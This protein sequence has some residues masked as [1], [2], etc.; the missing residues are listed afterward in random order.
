MTRFLSTLFL[1]ASSLLAQ[2]LYLEQELADDIYAGQVCTRDNWEHPCPVRLYPQPEGYRYYLEATVEV[3][4]EGLPVVTMK[5]RLSAY[6]Q[7]FDGADTNY[8]AILH[9]YFTNSLGMSLSFRRDDFGFNCGNAAYCASGLV[10]DHWAISDI[11]KLRLK[12]LK[13]QGVLQD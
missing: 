3:E 1:A 13:L 10:Y 5:T 7:N 12:G 11:T 2:P 9:F 8:G 6:P 4:Q